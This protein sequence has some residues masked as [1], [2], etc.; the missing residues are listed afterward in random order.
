MTFALFNATLFLTEKSRQRS[1]MNTR[2]DC[3]RQKHDTTDGRASL[4][5]LKKA[6]HS[7]KNGHYKNSIQLIDKVLTTTLSARTRLRLEYF[8]ID[9]L[10]QSG[11]R[12]EC[13]ASL[14]ILLKEFPGQPLASFYYAIF[15][16]RENRVTDAL[17]RLRFIIK[18]FPDF[19]NAYLVLADLLWNSNSQDEAI[20]VLLKL[21][22]KKHFRRSG[23]IHKRDVRAGLG[24]MFY[25]RRDYAR[26][27][28]SLEHSLQLG[29]K[30]NFQHYALLARCYRELDRPAMAQ[31]CMTNHLRFSHPYY[32]RLITGYSA[33][34]WNCADKQITGPVT[35]SPS[36]LTIAI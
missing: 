2:Q 3:F 22:N 1:S 5:S 21:A 34:A 16:A 25:S 10:Y 20:F 24:E 6:L 26:S 32:S 28:A 17:S 29:K 11:Q 18:Q 15:L 9:S 33:P 14:D 7:Y 8:R 27:A 30:E 31:E 12:D 36:L 19:W 13:F 4:S 35:R 23:N